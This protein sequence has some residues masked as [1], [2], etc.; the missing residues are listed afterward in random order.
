M[1]SVTLGVEAIAWSHALQEEAALL[2]GAGRA[3]SRT[4]G[5]AP[6]AVR[7]KCGKGRGA[8]ASPPGF[9]PCRAYTYAGLAYGAECYCGNRLP[10]TAAKPEECNSEC[11]GEKGS[12]CGGLDRLSVYRV[13]ELR[14]GARRRKCVATRERR[15]RSPQPGRAR[16]LSLPL[17]SLPLSP[18]LEAAKGKG[19]GRGGCPLAAGPAPGSLPRIAALLTAP[20]QGEVPRAAALGL[21]WGSGDS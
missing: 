8:R 11:K 3:S 10:G 14:A 12:L 20:E 21:P 1:G 13:E 4:R 6:A 15:P 7:D 9:V 19:A 2:P 17:A 16:G 18:E 5:Q